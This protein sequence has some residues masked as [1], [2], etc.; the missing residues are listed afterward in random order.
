VHNIHHGNLD[1]NGRGIQGAPM[2]TTDKVGT[3]GHK[4]DSTPVI[5]GAELKK[6]HADASSRSAVHDATPGPDHSGAPDK[7][8]RTSDEVRNGDD[9]NDNNV[10]TGTARGGK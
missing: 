9:F 5:E 2:F 8:T 3:F 6:A 7:Y 10:I 1:N 4:A